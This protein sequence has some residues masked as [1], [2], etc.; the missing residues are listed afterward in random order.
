MTTPTYLMAVPWDPTRV[1]NVKGLV[2]QTGATVVWDQV[3]DSMET[4]MRMLRTAGEG[5]G[6]FLEDDIELTPNW[7]TKIEAA[8][9]ERPDDVIQFFSIRK[10]DLELGS[11]YEA[12]RNF[13]MNQC[14]YLPPGAASDLLA[15]APG[16]LLDHPESPNAYDWV[17]RGWMQRDRRRYWMHVPSLVQHKKWRSVIDPRRSSGRASVTFEENA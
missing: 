17:M 11:R 10:K 2:E 7:R 15:Y 8:I 1:K 9:A 5:P 12:G 14:Y 16:W 6:I 13:S 4:W 3:Q